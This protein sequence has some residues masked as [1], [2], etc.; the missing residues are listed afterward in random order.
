MHEAREIALP[1]NLARSLRLLDDAEL[2]RRTNAVIDGVQQLERNPL[3]S[4]MATEDETGDFPKG[5]NSCYLYDPLGPL[6]A[7][8][9]RQ[10]TVATALP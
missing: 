5:Q 2:D 7:K 3:I 9:N 4:P 6:S 10:G 1:A 8:A